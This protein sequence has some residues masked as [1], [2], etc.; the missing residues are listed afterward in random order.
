MV[1]I[2]NH[3]EF[4]CVNGKAEVQMED[5]GIAGGKMKIFK[6][7]RGNGTIRGPPLKAPSFQYGDTELLLSTTS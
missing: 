2:I 1:G 5:R 4:F 3:H 7:K 6:S